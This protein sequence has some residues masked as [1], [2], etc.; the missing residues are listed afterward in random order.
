MEKRLT[1]QCTHDI[2]LGAAYQ[3]AAHS[4][5]RWRHLR[6]PW[7][8]FVKKKKKRMKKDGVWDPELQETHPSRG[9]AIR[10][11]GLPTADLG[12]FGFNRHLSWYANRHFR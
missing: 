5:P 6:S 11:K 2:L 10:N 1:R 7:Q 3:G 8:L 4:R 12:L 9:P